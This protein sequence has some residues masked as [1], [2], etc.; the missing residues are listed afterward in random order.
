MQRF[1]QAN[2]QM[3]QQVMPQQQLQLMPQQLVPQPQMFQHQ[4]TMLQPQQ[5]QQQQVQPQQMYNF[6][7]SSFDTPLPVLPF[8]T[9][10]ATP[11]SVPSPP[12]P[13]AT[14]IPPPATPVP[15]PPTT[16]IPPPPPPTAPIPPPPTPSAKQVPKARG[17][18]AAEKDVN[19][20]ENTENGSITGDNAEGKGPITV[21]SCELLDQL[22]V[23]CV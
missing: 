14:S 18:R 13:P 20:K 1:L 10:L 8:A 16:P 17:R 23:V 15:P 22:P 7:H 12:P 6:A 21:I 2:P 4:Q 3:L 11:P 5:V 9:Q 19:D